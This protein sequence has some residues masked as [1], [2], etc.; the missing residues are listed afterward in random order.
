MTATHYVA[1]ASRPGTRWLLLGSLALNLFFI[2]I[3]IA[4][5]VRPAP[6]ARN[7]DRDVFV[8][9]ER[10]AERLPKEDAALL[11]AQM[12]A[13]RDAIESTQKQYRA[14]Q[15]AIREIIREEPFDPGAL[16]A[17]MGE[18]R[19]A[20]QAFDSAVQNAFATA[21]TQMSQPGRVALADWRTRRGA[22]DK[23]R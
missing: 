19:A 10:L 3:A 12:N 11:I 21:T 14:A 20:R 4:I 13:N 1:A 8:R 22:N 5:A 6:Q 7:W 18:T 16:R 15:E 2:G 9:T 17:A 23:N